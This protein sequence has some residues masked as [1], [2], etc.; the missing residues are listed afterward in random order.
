MSPFIAGDLVLLGPDLPHCWKLENQEKRKKNSASSV[1]V[2]FA[3][4]ALGE[5]F[6]DNKEMS[7]IQKMLRRSR[8]GIHFTATSAQKAG[9]QLIALDKEQHPFRKLILFLEL[10][11]LLANTK[12][13]TLLNKEKETPAP[14]VLHEHARI[15]NTMAYIVEHFRTQI[16]L[17]KAAEIAGMT[18]TAFCKYF[19]KLT[20]KT[21]I[22]TVMEYR[23]NYA[24]QQLVNTDHP[25]A[26]ISYESGFGDVSHF[27]KTFR[28]KKKISPLNYRKKFSTEW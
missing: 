24:I 8:Q 27:Y 2:Q 6:F 13:Y 5:R 12:E 14:E 15:N 28:H 26:H 17:P 22:E 16:S 9:D 25:V 21:F 1:V 20:R 23:I 7:G 19:K 11:Q 18:P 3:E 10:L 4:T